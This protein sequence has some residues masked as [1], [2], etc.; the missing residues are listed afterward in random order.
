MQFMPHTAKWMAENSG[1]EW[2]EFHTFDPVLNVRLGSRYLHHLS[3]RY[4]GRMD[5]A[6]TAYNR[7]PH[8][9]G[10]ILRRNGKLPAD[11]HAFYSA[12]VFERY[13]NLRAE[14]GELPL[15]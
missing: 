10:A 8:N 14:F 12:K 11:I 7:G 15:Q 9:T 3:L 5:L 6:L 1:V 2:P 13:R 4:D